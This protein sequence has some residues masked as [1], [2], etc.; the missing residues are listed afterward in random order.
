MITNKTAHLKDEH[1]VFVFFGTKCNQEEEYYFTSNDL[2]NMYY[3]L[4]PC[5]SSWKSQ[6]KG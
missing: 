2:Y 3:D 1:Y 5:K 6:V 4:L